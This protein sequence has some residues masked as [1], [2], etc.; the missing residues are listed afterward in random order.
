MTGASPKN[1]SEELNA[2]SEDP[3]FWNDPAKA[4][5]LMRERNRLASSMDDVRE[6]EREA[7]EAVDL[8]ELADSEGDKCNVRRGR[9]VAA[10][11]NAKGQ[12]RRT[13][14]AAFR[15]GRWQRL[16]HRESCRGG[17]HRKPGLGSRCCGA[18][19]FDGR[20]SDGF[21]VEEIEEYAWRDGR[22]QI[23]D[24]R[25]PRRQ[26]LWLAKSREWGSP[27]GSYLAL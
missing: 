12:S 23:R 2:L 16:L 15:R 26:R 4:Q 19:M 5:S 3:A 11:R 9:D 1:V 17:R 24:A 8:W 25:D 21:K 6:L 7:Q 13:Q 14:C 22:H 20:A 27:S 10:G 18:C